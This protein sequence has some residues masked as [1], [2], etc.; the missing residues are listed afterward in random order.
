[1]KTVFSCA[2]V[3][4]LLAVASPT[5]DGQGRKL[6]IYISADMEGVV[7]AVTSDQLGPTDV[8]DDDVA[9]FIYTS[10]TTG[11]PKAVMQTHRTYVLTGQAFPWWTGLTDQDRLMTPLPL[12]ARSTA[13]TISRRRCSISSSAPIHTVS[14]FCWGP[15][16]CSTA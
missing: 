7:G 11:A 1:M 5:S 6:K 14:K 16:T 15:T 4:L 8:S 10:G 3:F 12:S 9:V 13:S 2:V